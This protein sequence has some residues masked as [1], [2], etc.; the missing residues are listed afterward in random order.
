MLRSRMFTPRFRLYFGYG[1]FF[2]AAAF[3]VGLSTQLQVEGQ[4]IGD[5]LDEQGIVET[6]TGPLSLGWKGG[7]GNHLAYTL[8]V[9]AAASSFF[10]A[11]LLITY[12]DADPEA[13]AE[14]IQTESVPLTRA[15]SG[16]NYA[17]I[18]VAAS[19]VLIGIGWA[20]TEVLFWG[21]IAL[22]VLASGTWA[23]RAWAERATGD[24]DVN[25]AI[26]HRYIDPLR[27]P[28]LALIG[29]GFVVFA[30]SRVLLAAPG[31]GPSAA[32]FGLVALAFF[33]VCV[34]IALAPRLSRSLVVGL[35]VVGVLAMAGGMVW[36]LVEGTR[37]IEGHGGGEG[38][39]H[40][41]EGGGSA[42]AGTE[43]GSLAPR[44]VV[45]AGV[46]GG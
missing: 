8:L 15:P 37:E 26:Y 38:V 35:V 21:G 24:D 14:A 4:T 40:S 3:V 6:V 11:G 44:V 29:I 19:L 33:G 41:E 25:R 23:L 42:P 28:A 2:L 12:R 17:P 43:E 31:K 36:G 20:A 10:F 5:V 30:F 45:P 46:T 22:L 16:T 34:A 18:L 13:Q 27:I 7:V 39:E 9:V 1:L 32:A